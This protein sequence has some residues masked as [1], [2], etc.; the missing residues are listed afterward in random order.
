MPYERTARLEHASEFRDRARIIPSVGEEAER[1][2]EIEHRVEAPSPARWQLSHVAPRVLERRS[3]AASARL[4]DQVLGV[5]EP[6]HV[7]PGLGERVRV[8]TLPARDVE[9]PGA[10]RQCKNVDEPRNLMAVAFF[11]EDGLVLEQV[12][13]IEVRLPPFALPSGR[14][15]KN[16][17]S[18]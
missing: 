17:G 12:V 6:L 7:E 2:E 8:A 13:G 18:R 14:R 11:C 16:T 1:R 10:G 3:G 4:V 9:N 15:Q 5:V